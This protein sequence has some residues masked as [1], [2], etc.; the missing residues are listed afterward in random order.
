MAVTISTNSTLQCCKGHLVGTMSNLLNVQ[1]AIPP[2][3]LI[4]FCDK[5]MNTARKI[6]FNTDQLLAFNRVSHNSVNYVR[7]FFIVAI[8]LCG[9]PHET[10]VS[11]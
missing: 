5:V 11:I 9:S 2:L 8:F 6:C 7:A 3:L 4:M 1:K 10:C